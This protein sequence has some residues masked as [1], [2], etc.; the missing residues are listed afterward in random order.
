MLSEKVLSIGNSTMLILKLLSERDMYG[1]EM[2]EELRRRSQNVFEM[3]AGTLY[4]L[5]HTMEDNG[6]VIP[7][8]KKAG[9]RKTRKYYHI[10]E[11]GKKVFEQKHTEWQTYA[12]AIMNVL[13]AENIPEHAEAKGNLREAFLTGGG[14]VG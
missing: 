6:Y 1:Y 3:K 13:G 14:L 4:P 2:V 8:E 11:E 9:V 7:Y 12:Q 10:T 5:L